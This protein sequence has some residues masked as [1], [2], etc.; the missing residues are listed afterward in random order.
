MLSLIQRRSLAVA[1]AAGAA[2]L[3]TVGLMRRHRVYEPG[4]DR[5]GLITF[6]AITERELVSDA[7]FSGTVRKGPRLY[8]TYDRSAPRGK[9]KCP[10]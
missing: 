1:V 10:T 6:S 2:L 3:L 5:V 4:G 8:S 7:T 9:Q